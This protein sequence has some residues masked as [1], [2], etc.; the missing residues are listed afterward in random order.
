[1]A[2]Q[3]LGHPGVRVGVF[4]GGIELLLAA[5]AVAAGDRERHHHPVADLKVVDHRAD[6]D[7][8]AHELVAQDVALLH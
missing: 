2:H 4:A 7:H 1:V 8:F 3:L 5:P 6:L